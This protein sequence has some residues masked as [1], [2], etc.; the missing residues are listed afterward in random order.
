MTKSVLIMD[1]NYL[2]REFLAGALSRW[3]YEVTTAEGPTEALR[4]LRKDP[5][6]MMITD[7]L[8]LNGDLSGFISEALEGNDK[9]KV[10]VCTTEASGG[11]T[12]DIKSSA[13]AV[14]YKPFK[15]ADLKSALLASM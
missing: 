12:R 1:S 11:L 13:A 2:V 5:F 3:G 6:G 4:K 10:I 7:A 9:L 14:L 15:L 8:N